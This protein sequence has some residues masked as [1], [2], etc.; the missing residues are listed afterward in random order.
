[1]RTIAEIIKE[2]KEIA[3]HPK[4]AMEDYKKETGKGD[5]RRRQGTGKGSKRSRACAHPPCP[6]P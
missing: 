3:D 6:R 4:K 2:F 1:M 5:H